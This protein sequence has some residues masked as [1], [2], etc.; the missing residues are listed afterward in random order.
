MRITSPS[1]VRWILILLTCIILPSW[2]RSAQAQDRMI[3][4]SDLN[5]AQGLAAKHRRLVLL[6]FW[7]EQ[8]APCERLER[9]VFNRQE[10]IRAINHHYVPVKIK[11][12]DNRELAQ[13]YNVRQW[14]TDV[15]LDASGKELFRA[16]SPQ[17]PNRYVN[18]VD[19]VAAHA[20]MRMTT[21]NVAQYGSPGQSVSQQYQPAETTGNHFQDHPANHHT[22]GPVAAPQTPQEN[23]FTSNGGAHAAPNAYS[24]SSGGSFNPQASGTA[25]ASGGRAA[26]MQAPYAN[27]FIAP[28]SNAP[29]NTGTRDTPPVNPQPTNSSF[30][31]GP[32]S[33]SPG[34]NSRYPANNTNPSNDFRQP[35]AN[36]SAVTSQGAYQPGRPTPNASPSRP[37]N[38]W[39][40][41]APARG[42]ANGSPAEASPTQPTAARP[43]TSQPV[44]QPYS[45]QPSGGSMTPQPQVNPYA[46]VM[47]RFSESATQAPAQNESAPSAAGTSSGPSAFGAPALPTNSP[48]PAAAQNATSAP[49]ASTT[50]PTPA[51]S[52]SR[53]PG[54]PAIDLDGFCPVS[55]VEQQAWTPGNPQYRENYFGRTYQFSSAEAADAFRNNPK[56]YAPLLS[57]YDPVKF[58]EQRVEVPGKREHGISYGNRVILFADEAS[59]ARFSQNPTYY[60][61]QAMQ[62]ITALEQSMS[63]GTAPF[64]N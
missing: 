27:Q 50:S 52:I 6:H 34:A 22:A 26:E 45:T 30:P 7:D 11:V 42:Y 28:P 20:R 14:P 4:G 9:N 13:H 49:N 43:G 44:S 48:N 12:S 3:W 53:S 1:S 32:I 58:A 15:I 54:V 31:A 18:M 25:P 38:P 5:Q 51:A 8:C 35:G 62:A 40:Q 39:E 2:A 64:Q 17:D 23:Q 47:N 63:R 16:V 59:L 56:R 46:Q 10:V 19:Q 57:G 55:L 29:Q 61:E 33:Q 60:F 41:P 37:A 36:P 21:P 24:L